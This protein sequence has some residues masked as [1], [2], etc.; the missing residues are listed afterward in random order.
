MHATA[1]LLVVVVVVATGDPPFCIPRTAIGPALCARSWHSLRF[2]F[3]RHTAHSES[4]AHSCWMSLIPLAALIPRESASSTCGCYSP[5]RMGRCSSRSASAVP[6]RH[7]RRRVRARAK[8]ACASA[9]AQ[10]QTNRRRALSLRLG[11][12]SRTNAT[13]RAMTRRTACAARRRRA[14][15][16]DVCQPAGCGA[17][18]DEHG[19][20]GVIDDYARASFLCPFPPSSHTRCAQLCLYAPCTPWNEEHTLS[21]R[22]VTLRTASGPSSTAPVL[23]SPHHASERSGAYTLVLPRSEP[24]TRPHLWLRCALHNMTDDGGGRQLWQRAARRGLVRVYS[25]EHRRHRRQSTTRLAVSREGG[26]R[27]QNA[28]V[29][30]T[31]RAECRSRFEPIS[32]PATRPVASLGVTESRTHEPAGRSRQS[33]ATSATQT[34]AVATSQAAA[35]AQGSEEQNDA[36]PRSLDERLTTVLRDTPRRPQLADTDETRQP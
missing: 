8:R 17:E 28:D 24:R 10:A 9:S 16:P 14:L 5:R 36:R 34:P 23:G 25:L 19:A 22:D 27:L 32:N 21:A 11:L 31:C 30:G 1:R 7:R 35:S 29:S 3:G 6:F 20:V 33:P 26:P 12:S 4:E 13:R 18:P 15:R 2:R